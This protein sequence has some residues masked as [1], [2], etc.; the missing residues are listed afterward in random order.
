[1]LYMSRSLFHSDGAF[2]SKVTSHPSKQHFLVLD[3]QTTDGNCLLVSWMGTP[4]SSQGL[5]EDMKIHTAVGKATLYLLN[6]ALR[7]EKSQANSDLWE[8]W[9]RTGSTCAL[10]PRPRKEKPSSSPREVASFSKGLAFRTPI[11]REGGKLGYDLNP[12]ISPL[13][14]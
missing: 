2:Q 12:A 13:D 8:E 1:M 14:S 11:G 10:P 5:M 4:S 3:T 6:D 9:N 7:W